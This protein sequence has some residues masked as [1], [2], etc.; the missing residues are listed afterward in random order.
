MSG[1]PRPARRPPGAAREDRLFV[2]RRSPKHGRGAFAA[3]RIRRGTRI[4]EY[5]GERI[6]HDEADARYDDDAMEQ[7]HT[8]LM[9]VNRKWV[10]DAAVGGNDARF[11]NHSCEPNA[12]I[13]VERGRV[14]IDA[15][16]DIPPGEEITYDYAYEREE[17]DDDAVATSRYPCR[18]GAR[19]CRGTILAPRD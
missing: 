12:E 2:L 17:G 19:R 4:V 6:T 7:H 16:A 9:I 3:R 18:C 13:V 15:I 11:I 14:F 8:L 10:L 5:T 1:G